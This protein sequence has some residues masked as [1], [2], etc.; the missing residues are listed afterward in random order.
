MKK[1]VLA[2]IA[3]LSLILVCSP[4]WAEEA[5][6]PA[7]AD[8]FSRLD[9]NND[10]K[11]TAD[12]VADQHK[13]LF[14][15]LLRKSDANEDGALTKEEFASGVA[16]PGVDRKLEQPRPAGPR[17]AAGI[18]FILRRLDRNGDGKIVP[19]E[20]PA[21]NRAQFVELLNVAD[22]DADGA[23]TFQ[24]ARTALDEI[25]KLYKSFQQGTPQQRLARAF[26]YLDSD[27]DGKISPD[28]VP[29]QQKGR[30]E[31]LV[32][33]ADKDGDGKLTREEFADGA[34]KQF[35]AQS[36]P[37]QIAD[38]LLKRDE[39]KDGGINLDEAPPKVKENF[40]KAD[41]NG[42]GKLDRE[43][44]VTA[45]RY[46]KQMQRGE[47]PKFT[48]AQVVD[49]LL[50]R[51]SDGDGTLSKDEAPEQMQANFARVDR[52]SDGELDRQELTVAA[53]FFLKRMQN[54]RD[55]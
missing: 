22:K 52:N 26:K 19:D 7:A 42:D 49:R 5:A 53:E 14:D 39:N 44:I 11:V 13:R 27:G 28:E 55:K 41:T 1:L 8:I 4:A 2:P 54:R 47:M 43:E 9:T 31:D 30:I 6:A 21:P 48:A 32:D 20:I 3:A 40:E 46:V 33:L 37:E 34:E 16:E 45:V 10:G 35:V 15:R 23:L 17:S 24:E 29:D 50:K 12:E 38:E 18:V 25:E 36:S 51:D